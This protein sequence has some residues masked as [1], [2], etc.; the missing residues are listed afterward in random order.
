ME[1]YDPTRVAD[2][3]RYAAEIALSAASGLMALGQL[4]DIGRAATRPRGLRRYRG[5]A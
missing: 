3:V 1:L 5:N 2:T 4:W